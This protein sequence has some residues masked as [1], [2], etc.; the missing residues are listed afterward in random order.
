MKLSLNWLKDYVDIEMPPD[1][2]AHLLTMAGLE[3]DSFVAVGQSLSGIV[4][5]KI[6]ELSPHPNADRLTLC[7][8]DTG[9][10]RVPVVCGAPNLKEGSLVALALPGVKLPGGLVI[11]ESR[12]RGE[13]SKGMLLA[14]DEMGLTDDHTGI[15]LLPSGLE[16]GTPLPSAV[17]IEDWT[18]DIELTPNRPDCASVLG[19]AREIAAATG[20]ELKRPDTDIWES[21]PAIEDLTS[22]TIMDTDACPR[23]AAGVIQDIELGPSPFWMRYRL[24]LSGIRSINNIVDVTNYVMLEVGQ[25][26]HA[27]DYDRLK[28]NRIMVKRAHEGEEFST[29]DGTTHTLSRETLMICDGKRAVAVAGIM[30]GLNS[31]IFEGTNNVF[32]ESAFFDPVVIRRGSKRLGLSTE[33]SYRFERGADIGGVTTAL[34]RAVG[35]NVGSCRWKSRGRA[36]R[37]LLEKALPS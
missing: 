33:A 28:E 14:E 9:G 29:L 1:D 13:A 16:P 25:P 10:R 31:E 26:L 32:I 15:M 27:F 12:I 7:H 24:Y 5:A 35:L 11:K 17:P 23:Y 4:V 3:V 36:Y 19:I 21:G 20:K 22:V 37:Q 8:V 34:K 2:L 18:F 6:L 30:G